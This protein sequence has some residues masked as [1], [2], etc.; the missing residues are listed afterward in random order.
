MHLLNKYGH[1]V[2]HVSFKLFMCVLYR[3]RVWLRYIIHMLYLDRYVAVLY[4]CVGDVKTKWK[5]FYS[6]NI[7]LRKIRPFLACNSV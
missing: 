7:D 6:P 5:M 4:A 2:G 3:E 1:K